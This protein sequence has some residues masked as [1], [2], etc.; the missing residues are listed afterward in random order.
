MSTT[1]PNA[2][3]SFAIVAYPTSELIIPNEIYNLFAANTSTLNVDVDCF[4]ERIQKVQLDV[5]K[6]NLNLVIGVTN[7]QSR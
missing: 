3:G 5:T 6:K 2:E 1:N 7:N 4:V